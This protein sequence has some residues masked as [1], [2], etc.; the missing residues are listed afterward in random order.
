M[1]QGWTAIDANLIKSIITK[2]FPHARVLVFGSRLKGN[3]KETS[4]L[5]LCLKA[6]K[7]LDLAAWTLLEEELS[8][9]DI[10]FKVDLC[11]WFRIAEEFRE[12]V[13]QSSIEL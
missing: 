9:T 4:D 5:D 12:H 3:F 11:D 6:D 10:P 2:H 7:P 13:Q 8:Q 1:S